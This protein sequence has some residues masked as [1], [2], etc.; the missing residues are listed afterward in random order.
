MYAILPYE[1]DDEDVLQWA[2]NTYP[3]QEITEAM[4]QEV[5]ANAIIS[6]IRESADNELQDNIYFPTN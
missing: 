5:M 2:K 3:D 4:L 6:E 1:Y